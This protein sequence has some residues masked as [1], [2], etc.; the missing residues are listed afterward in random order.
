[1]A[2][3]YPN[4]GV[5]EL[6]PKNI[7]LEARYFGYDPAEYAARV[8]SH[9]G[10]HVRRDTFGLLTNS[11]YDEY[12]SYSREFLFQNNRRPT[13]TERFNIWEQVKQ[14]YPGLPTGKV[15]VQSW[16]Q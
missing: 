10:K 12:L 7:E 11:H 5:I 4:R 3:Y 15:P 6:Y 14:D 13:L 1:M 9:E 8:F 16:M 2:A